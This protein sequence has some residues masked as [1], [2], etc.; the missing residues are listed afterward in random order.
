[1]LKQHTFALEAKLLTLQETLV[2]LHTKVA[3]YSETEEGL[4]APANKPHEEGID[5]GKRNIRT[6]LKTPQGS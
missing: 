5:H 6:R 2:I 1:M 4:K 3:L